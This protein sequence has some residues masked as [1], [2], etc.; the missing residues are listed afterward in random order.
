VRPRLHAEHGARGA[1]HGGALQLLRVRR[2][3]RLSP[4]ALGL[5]RGPRSLVLLFLGAQAAILVAQHETFFSELFRFPSRLA[6]GV[7]AG[8]GSSLPLLA[9]VLAAAAAWAGAPWTWERFAAAG[10]AT[11][12]AAALAVYAAALLTGAL[13]PGAA[14]T[15]VVGSAVLALAERGARLPASAPA[16]RAAPSV[17]D[18]FSALFLATLLVPAVFPYIAFDA[19]LI[20]AW[21]AYAMKDGTFAH[22]VTGVIRP[23]YPPVDSILLWL[24]IHDPLFEGRLGPW[25]LLVL[26]AVFFRAR[27]ARVA[28]RL[29]PA[30]LLFL[31]A[32][33]NVWQGV[34]TFYADVP[35]M[36]LLVTGALLA[37]GLPGD[38]A[39]GPFER[40]AA[41]LCLSAA[42]LV[43]P[44]GLYCL[45]V[46]ALAA[47]LGVRPRAGAAAAGPALAAVLAYATWALRPAAL[48][49][50]PDAYRFFS[51]PGEWRQAGE[52]AGGALATTLLTYLHALQGQWLSHKGLGAAFWCVLVVAASRARTRGGAADDLEGETRFYGTATFLS[53]AS[54][55]LVY[56]VIPFTSDV[57]G[58]IGS[59]EFPTWI[60]AYRNYARVGMGRMVV[61][62]L[63]FFVL[64]AAAALASRAAR[65]AAPAP[66]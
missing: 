50:L 23:E 63:P 1:A 64:Y 16:A 60:L 41:A 42:V 56:A 18:A 5:S 61:H 57:R 53:L 15:A 40:V 62:L 29:A 12:A 59:D 19:N 47:L 3:E 22:A 8:A 43:R 24:G 58:A 46:L 49:P 30:G 66:C 9:A 39:R 34:A 4:D 55:A 14:W 32:T 27:L 6:G 48:R 2:D 51:H 44:D 33:V 13:V 35:L 28:P 36:V 37:L 25:L 65:E 20:W 10:V 17:F 52:T 45:G 26:F 31:L 11:L 21:R 7:P 38:A 54:V